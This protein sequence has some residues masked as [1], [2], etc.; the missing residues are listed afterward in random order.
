RPLM[1]GAIENV[2]RLGPSRALTGP[3]E[4]GDVETVQA[5]LSALAEAAGADRERLE[6]LY[7]TLGLSAL[8]LVARRDG[9]LSPAHQVL[10]ALLRGG[11]GPHAPPESPC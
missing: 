6:G 2:A 8:A 1:E 3:I 7:R 4:R 11:P 10:A 5:H 9:E